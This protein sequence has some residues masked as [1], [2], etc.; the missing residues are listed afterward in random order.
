MM[1]M[2]TQHIRHQL[3]KFLIVLRLSWKTDFLPRYRRY[4]YDVCHIS[5]LLVSQSVEVQIS[6]GKLLNMPVS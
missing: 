6:S 4:G 3:V 5:S 1:T 2:F